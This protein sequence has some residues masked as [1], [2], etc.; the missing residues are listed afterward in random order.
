MTDYPDPM[1]DDFAGT[2]SMADE[3]KNILEI[4]R[5]FE[6]PVELLGVSAYEISSIYMPRLYTA[7]G[8]T[9]SYRDI[10]TL[11][12]SATTHMKQAAG[13]I[14]E[15]RLRIESVANAVRRGW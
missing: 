1:N 11:A 8:D 2:G 14:G 13:N 7:I 6:R 5:L 15:M 10:S 4:R 3:V 12:D 9:S